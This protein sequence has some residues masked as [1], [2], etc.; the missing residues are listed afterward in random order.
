M[1]RV[2][3][4]IQGCKIW[5]Q[6]EEDGLCERVFFTA[7]ADIDCDGSGGNPDNDPY[8]QNDTTLHHNGKA[9]NAYEVAFGVVPPVV[10]QRTK[11]KVLGCR[12][13]IHYLKTG[14]FC[15]AVVGDIGPTSKVGELSVAAANAVH[16]TSDPNHGGEDDLTMV[17]Y[18]LWPNVPAIVDGIKYELQSYK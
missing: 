4:T 6:S 16:M 12:M 3:D 9:L 15:D 2:I 17:V 8:F 18:E 1:L 7:D 13:R 10:C 14:Y 5:H 11:G